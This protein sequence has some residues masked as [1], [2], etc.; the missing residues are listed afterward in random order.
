[1]VGL[2]RLFSL[3]AE[4]RGVVL[5]FDGVSVVKEVRKRGGV[6]LSEIAGLVVNL[7]DRVHHTNTSIS[8]FPHESPHLR[9]VALR[10]WRGAAVPSAGSLVD[11][12]ARSDQV[13][14]ATVVWRELRPTEKKVTAPR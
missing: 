6:E 7:R 4:R 13:P 10:G 14:V 1:M 5:G 2:R 8:R 11:Y 12:L 9:R 3:G